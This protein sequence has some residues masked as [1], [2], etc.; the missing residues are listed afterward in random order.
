MP[1]N[2]ITSLRILLADLRIDYPS[3]IDLNTLQLKITERTGVINPEKI[4]TYVDILC[5]LE[6]LERI[7]PMAFKIKI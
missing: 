7:N 2:V 5:Q 4:K 6:Y 3:E 1:F